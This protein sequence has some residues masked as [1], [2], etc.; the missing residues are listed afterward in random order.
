MRFWKKK[1]KR[2]YPR[3]FAKRLTWRIMF[4]MLIFMGIPTFLV[5]WLAYGL[6]FVGAT[7]ICERLV[8][9]EHEEIRRISS[10][11]Y[12]ASVNTAP[13]I[14]DNLDQPDKM[15]GIVERMLKKNPY[16]MS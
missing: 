1:D 14:E 9:G 2:P 10:D 5:F 11:L 7:T 16:M 4:R 15:K 12:V 3:S 6:V 13:V 8:H